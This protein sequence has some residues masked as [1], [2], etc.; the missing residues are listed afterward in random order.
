MRKQKLVKQGKKIAAMLL[1][2]AMLLSVAACGCSNDDKEEQ[3]T[4]AEQPQTEPETDVPEIDRPNANTVTAYDKNKTDYGLSID[5]G[6]EVHDIS[7]LLFGIFIED[8]NFAADGGLYAEKVVNRSFE[9]TKLAKNDEM[10]GWSVQ[11]T[12]NA[13]VTVDDKAGSLNENNTNYLVMENTSG[14]PAGVKNAGFLDGLSVE[15]GAAYSFSIYAKGLDGYTG[16]VTVNIAAGTDVV[17][18]GKIDSVTGEWKKYTLELTSSKTAHSGVS[19]Q[20]LIDNGKAAIDMVSLFPKD[21]YKGRANGMRKDLAEML[22]GLKPRFLR[23][24]GGCVIEGYG[25]ETAYDWKASIGVGQ[26]REPLLFGGVYGDVA[27][28]E[29]GTNLWTDIKA[30][31][32][33]WPSYMTYGLGFY[34]YFQLAEDLGAVGVPVVNCGLYCQVRGSKPVP[35]DSELFEQYIQDA[36][37]LVEFC[38]G[39]ANTKWGKVRIS[40]G[41]EAPFELKYI[42]IGNENWGNDYY[43][44]YTKFVEAFAA[45]KAERPELFDGVEIMYSAGVDDGDSGRDYMPSYAYAKKWLDK[46]KDADIND[47]AGAIDHHYYNSPDWFLQ[48]TDYYD[49]KNYSRD[50][51]NMASSTFGGGIDVFVGEYAAQSNTLKAALAEA[52]YMTGIERNGD[53]IRMAA[54]APLFGNLTAT[55]W[56]PDLIWFNNHLCTGSINYYV[57]KIFANNQGTKLLGSELTGAELKFDDLKGMIGAGTWNTAAEFDNVKIVNNDT[58]EVLG[59]QKFDKD[60]FGKEWYKA[61]DGAF[62]VKDGKL[63]QSSRIT[64]DSNTGSSAYFGKTDW[65]NYTYTVEATKTGGSE[66]FLIPFAVQDKDNNYFWNIGG[67]N[68]TVSC[69]QQV[70]GGAKS[71]QLGGT[72]KDFKAKTGQTY[73]LKVVVA[74]TNVKCYIDDKLY[75]DYELNAGSQSEAY[76]VVSTDETGDVIIKLVN[77]TDSDRVFAV[78][79]AN[80]G[81]VSKDAEV[82]QVA[83]QS[84]QDDN[85]LGAKEACTMEELDISGFSDKFNY[86]VPKYSVTVIRLHN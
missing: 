37:D 22:E 3:T 11:G 65:K 38:K 67:W 78:D 8:I 34:E 1:S 82:Y 26:D 36:L 75:V 29:Q 33:P 49:E 57:Q 24:P 44:R 83:G 61:A 46:N 30:T 84:L 23:F 79:I 71:G 63:I 16:A 72:V 2:S 31:N 39:D 25:I 55:H 28:R 17:A 47:F 14:S 66:G 43:Q 76:H 45:A 35:M 74:G 60:T 62:D 4:K 64:K 48:H 40:M 68:N 77:V 81:D 21:T 73:K 85:V 70:S 15:E 9:F 41:H 86:T 20:V 69:L 6:K 56:S 10:Y 59:E 80:A 52:A 50:T 27:A 7:D 12:A 42:G 18:S 53:I 58:G 19:L 13:K 5:A 32:D 54:Y 51:D